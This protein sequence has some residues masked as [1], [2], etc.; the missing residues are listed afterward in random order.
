MLFTSYIAILVA[1]AAG[2]R[3]ARWSTSCVAV[4]CCLSQDGSSALL[5]VGHAC[6]MR[7]T[8]VNAR[9]RTRASWE[10]ED[11]GPSSLGWSG[12][13]RTLSMSECGPCPRP[14]RRRAAW[15]SIYPYTTGL[16]YQL[17]GRGASQVRSSELHAHAHTTKRP[18]PPIAHGPVGPTQ[19]CARPGTG[20]FDFKTIM[21]Q[22]SALTFT[23][24][25]VELQ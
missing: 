18:T 17:R 7:G 14:E 24:G 23:V 22:L 2:A 10:V 11:L 9:R 21:V 13:A 6:V 5:Q 8:D 4:S 12:L 15:H 20:M 19:L 16:R 3:K 1:R 25:R